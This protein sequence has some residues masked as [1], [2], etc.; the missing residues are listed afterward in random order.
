[1]H[2]RGR[3]PVNDIPGFD[4]TAIDHATLVHHADRKSGQIVLP[5]FIETGHL[6]RFPTQERT[7]RL[8]TAIHDPLDHLF[9]D[10]DVQL[11]AGEVIQEEERPCP[12]AQKVIDVH[13]D[14]VDAHRVVLVGEEG[15]FQFCA[16]PV[17]AA[18]QLRLFHSVHGKREEAGK[19]ADHGRHL[20]N[21]VHQSIAGINVHSGFLVG[22]HDGF[23]V[24]GRLPGLTSGKPCS[25]RGQLSGG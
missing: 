3:Q 23:T 20:L 4:R 5:R 9:R 12:T 18:D 2:A 24:S 6:G 8:L 15:H 16:D 17:C 1:M 25:H 13:R 10:A 19:A 7:L 11:P 14:Q 22:D 21:P